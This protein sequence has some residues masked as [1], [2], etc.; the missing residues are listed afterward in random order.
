MLGCAPVLAV[1]LLAAGAGRG[2]APRDVPSTFFVAKSEN[3]N[4]V[5]YGLHLDASCAPLGAA[6][7][8]VYWRMLEQGPTATEPLLS[9]EQPA[10]G[11]SEQRVLERR[12]DGGR[13]ALRL[14]ALPERV[15][16][17][18]STA[19][20]GQCDTSA[21]TAIDGAQ[22]ALANVFVQLRW[23][24]GVDSLLLSGRALGDGRVVRERLAR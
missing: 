22:A 20:D 21:T 17:I 6:P 14:R 15:I 16:E 11:I 10:Y 9:R 3:R 2:E 4:Q 13:V 12:L 8:Y 19:R 18:T 24:F 1:V 23:P 5:H 7:V